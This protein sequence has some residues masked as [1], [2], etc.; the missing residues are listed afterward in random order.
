M[1]CHSP[2]K[3]KDAVE[4]R[5]MQQPPTGQQPD[6]LVRTGMETGQVQDQ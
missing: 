6:A 3:R 1:I 4:K 5:G 2:F